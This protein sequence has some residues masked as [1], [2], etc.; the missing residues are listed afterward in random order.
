MSELR[1]LIDSGI[2]LAAIFEPLQSALADADAVSIRDVMSVRDFDVAGVIEDQNGPVVGVVEKAALVAGTVREHAALIS[3]ESLASDS[4]P[5]SAAFSALKAR[6]RLFVLVGARVSGIATR[7]DL[8]KPPVRIYLFGLV[9]LLEMHLTFWVRTEFTNDDWQR[10]VSIGRLK[11]A[12]KVQSERQAAG[13]G[14]E[15]LDC[16]QLSDKRD[17]LLRCSERCEALQ[18]PG[19]KPSTRLFKRAEALRNLLAHGQHDLIDGSSWDELFDLVEWLERFL[20][21]SDEHLEQFAAAQ[22]GREPSTPWL[23]A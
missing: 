4:T 18:L 12:Q 9:S 22:A 1:A 20:R 23:S 16:L 5:L 2:T 3:V 15:L 6:S 13:Q 8:N 14:S 10:H 11:C 7:T 17:L 19:K 21:A